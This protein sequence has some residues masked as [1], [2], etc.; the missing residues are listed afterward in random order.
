MVDF[1]KGFVANASAILISHPFDVIKSRYQINNSKKKNIYNI[2][3][4]ILKKNGTKGLYRGIIPNIGTYPLFWAIFFQTKKINIQVTNNK[5]FNTFINSY[6]SG[7][8]ASTF[9]NPLFVLKTRLQVKN[10]NKI[11]IIRE[12]NKNK[13]IYFNGLNSTY[14]NNI[15]IGFQF[16]FYDYLKD[17]TNNTIFSS[18]TSKIICSSLFYP[19]D[20]IRINQRNSNTK[21]KIKD[22]SKNIYKKNG[23]CGFYNGLLLY[24]IVSTI[25]FTIMMLFIDILQ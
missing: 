5:T 8:I 18:F 6:I 19:F 25:N 15:K 17:K 11:K 7:N 21:I 24:N 3:T 22:I 14:F 9:T 1:I 2:Y 10:N 12:I 13:I 16:P 20:L 23:Y 4:N